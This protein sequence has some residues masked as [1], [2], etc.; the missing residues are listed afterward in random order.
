MCDG[1]MSLKLS[2]TDELKKN[3]AVNLLAVHT[4]TKIVYADTILYFMYSLFTH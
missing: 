2:S 4:I 1:S 3:V